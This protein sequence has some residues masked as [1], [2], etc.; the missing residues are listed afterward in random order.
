MEE[1]IPWFKN[2]F[3]ISFISMT[4]CLFVLLGQCATNNKV[5]S[6]Q[7]QNEELVKNV[8]ENTEIIKQFESIVKLQ[9]EQQF[10]QNLLYTDQL[11]RKQ[12]SSDD[13][14]NKLNVLNKKINEAKEAKEKN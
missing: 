11:N 10:T 5:T 3:I 14:I 2:P 6:V 8:E 4:F 7:K 9:I 13:I 1:K 12:I